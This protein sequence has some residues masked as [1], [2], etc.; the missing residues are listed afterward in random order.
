MTLQD[1]ANEIG[2]TLSVRYGALLPWEQQDEWQQQAN[3]WTVTLRLSGRRY[4]TSFWTGSARTREPNRED[5]L[6]ALLSDA[7]AG[8]KTFA[9]FCADFGYDEDSRRALRTWSACRAMSRKLRRLLGT[10]YAA[11][12]Q[13]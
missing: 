10:H 4:T 3:G 1:F 9:D 13:C 8:E 5:V 12:Q 11:A 2:L 7:Q 6:S